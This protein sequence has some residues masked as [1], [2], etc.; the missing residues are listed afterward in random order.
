MDFSKSYNSLS[1]TPLPYRLML[2]LVA[3]VVLSYS[4][5]PYNLWPLVFL[6][7]GGFYILLTTLQNKSQT[8]LLGFLF[9]LGYFVSGLSWIGNA[10]LVEGNEY[11]W[12][13]P[14][15][16][17][18]LP[19]ALSLMSA[20]YITLAAHWFN[21]KTLKGFLALVIFMGISEWVRGFA[22]TGF[23]W[24]LYGYSWIGL[25]PVAQVASLIGPYGLT[26]LTLFWGMSAGFLLLPDTQ[27]RNK[28]KIGSAALLSL[29]LVLGYGGWRLSHDVI[30]PDNVTLHIVQ[31]NIAQAEKWKAEKLAQ[32]FETHIELSTGALQ[33]HA[34]ATGRNIIIWP[35]TSIPPV[36]IY[37]SAV[38]QRIDSLLDSNTILLSGAMDVDQTSS[39]P[40]YYNALLLWQQHMG[41]RR[42]YAKT[43][44]VPFGEYIP[45]QS[46][47]PLE[48]VTK[49]SGFA[50]GE[51]PQSLKLSNVPPF[52]PLI[53]YEIIFPHS[54]VSTKPE[55]PKW[56]LTL[57]NDAWYRN[58]A[59]PYQH[60]TQA[61]F[62]AIEQGIPVIRA[63]NTGISGV[64]DPYGRV[65]QKLDLMYQGTISTPLP[66][67]AL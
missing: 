61:R 15:A 7:F 28:I 57:T 54:A 26:L 58:S 20:I 23:P 16:V 67:P 51:G 11:W 63:A 24:N 2:A 59:G 64:I 48:P 50:R 60:F 5:A 44:L 34:G 12:V 52:S 6:C 30:M 13:W 55:R 65:I 27:K 17:I 32:N 40:K 37:N 8:F 10:L 21:L 29:L 41:P 9:S 53:C 45:F 66:S 39:P 22:F 14:L 49:F 19:A 35:E 4:Q 42:I 43:H 18:A 38:Q 33:N 47:I 62:R 46:W 3:G 56:I 31:P 1:A 36:F 25:L